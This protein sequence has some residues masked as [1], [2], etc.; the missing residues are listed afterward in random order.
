M[1]EKNAIQRFAALAHELRYNAFRILAR[2]G[3]TGMFA[4]ELAR[5]LGAP[6]STLSPHLGRLEREQLIKSQR[7]G[8]HI[9]YSI[10]PEGVSELVQHLVDDCCEGRP[11]LCGGAPVKVECKA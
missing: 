6:A 11:E 9:L 10:N 7:Q 5:Q 4:G 2:R 8:A 3:E 1:D